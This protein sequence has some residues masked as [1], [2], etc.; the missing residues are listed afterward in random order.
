M[1]FVQWKIEDV[2][3]TPGN[4]PALAE[5][6]LRLR[7]LRDDLLKALTGATQAYRKRVP[8]ER[9]TEFLAQLMGFHARL[10][11][12]DWWLRDYLAIISLAFMFIVK[13]MIENRRRWHRLNDEMSFFETS[14][15]PKI[16]CSSRAKRTR[17]YEP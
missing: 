14:W 5:Y 12:G 8:G 4:N 10:I 13:S 7:P 3:Q 16:C 11:V 17:I 6:Q 15:K 2:A 9:D 1:K